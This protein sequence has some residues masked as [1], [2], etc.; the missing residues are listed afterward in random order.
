MSMLSFGQLKRGVFIF[1]LWRINHPNLIPIRSS[2][3]NLTVHM[4]FTFSNVRLGQS[5]EDRSSLVEM[6]HGTRSKIELALVTSH[7]KG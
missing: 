1:S 5:L 4:V 2:S 3:L 7:W 6:T